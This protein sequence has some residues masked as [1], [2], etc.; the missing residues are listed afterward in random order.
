ML[1][2]HI[3]LSPKV[4]TGSKPLPPFRVQGHALPDHGVE[5]VGEKAAWAA[6]EAADVLEVAGLLKI[7]L[8][9]AHSPP[10]VE[11]VPCGDHLSGKTAV[12]MLLQPTHT[13]LAFRIALS[14]SGNLS[15][16]VELSFR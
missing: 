3:P 11:L 6:V 5:R 8:D 13:K 10:I 14:V 12:S 15:R 16:E 1:P 4:A 2:A 9:E 7:T